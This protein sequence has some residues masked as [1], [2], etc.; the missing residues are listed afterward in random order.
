M[1]LNNKSLSVFLIMVVCCANLNA[2]QLSSDRGIN[3]PDLKGHLTLVSDFHS[4]TVFTDVDAWPI[5]TME[6]QKVKQ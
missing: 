1:N 6:V 3:F 2:Q 5:I 4:H